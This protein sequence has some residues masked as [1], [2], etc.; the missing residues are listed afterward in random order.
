MSQL[1]LPE[2]VLSWQFQ[3][4]V[5]E[6]YPFLSH[7]LIYTREVLENALDSMLTRYGDPSNCVT[8]GMTY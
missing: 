8:I 1:F 7:S 4:G 2:T 6:P 3:L 5:K